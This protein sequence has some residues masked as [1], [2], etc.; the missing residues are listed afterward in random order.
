MKCL[1]PRKRKNATAAAEKTGCILCSDKMLQCLQL[2]VIY[3][4]TAGPTHGLF[5]FDIIGKALDS[6][7][8]NRQY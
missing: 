7:S 4:R 6:P 3:M 1:I 5:F 8:V 2:S